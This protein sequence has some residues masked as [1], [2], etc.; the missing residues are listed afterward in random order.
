MA[1]SRFAPR[2]KPGFFLCTSGAVV[3][4]KDGWLQGPDGLWAV[5]SSGIVTLG[6]ETYIVST[7]SDEQNS[8]DD[9]C[10]IV[11]HVSSVVASAL[12]PNAPPANKPDA[13][14]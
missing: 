2:L 14:F 3:A 6:D 9:G 10:S 7:Y 11:N 8:I 4:M 1:G 5:N 13:C 12:L